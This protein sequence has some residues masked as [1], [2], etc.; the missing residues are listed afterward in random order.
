MP[1]C[2]RPENS[3]RADAVLDEAESAANCEFGL[4]ESAATTDLPAERGRRCGLGMQSE[5]LE[6]LL[7]P[8]LRFGVRLAKLK[9]LVNDA[10]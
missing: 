5:L 10:F 7:R 9:R 6:H 2:D 1:A 4:V 3:S 8:L